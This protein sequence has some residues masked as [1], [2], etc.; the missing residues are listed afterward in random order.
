M[1]KILKTF[2]ERPEQVVV[3]R[4]KVFF[5][6][7]GI[8]EVEDDIGEV[9]ITVPGYQVIQEDAQGAKPTD[10]GKKSQEKETP[11]VDPPSDEI[12]DPEEDDSS[13]EDETDQEEEDNSASE[14]KEEE[15]EE[16]VTKPATKRPTPARRPGTRK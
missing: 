3:K 11:S 14:D 7:N 8:A 2:G 9:L 1:K 5:D 13:D 15:A 12:S 6:S 4:T 10:K 16:V